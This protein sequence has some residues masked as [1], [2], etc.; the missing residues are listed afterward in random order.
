MMIYV[1]R[2]RHGE[3][4]ATATSGKAFDLWAETNGYDNC[5]DFFSEDDFDFEF[6]DD[7]W[8]LDE[9]GEVNRVELL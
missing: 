4:Y 7:H 8:F 2:G 3:L 1:V 6:S 5:A 9:G